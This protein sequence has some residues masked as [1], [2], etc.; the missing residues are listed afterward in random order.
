MAPG[1][2]CVN[3]VDSGTEAAGGCTGGTEQAD[4]S[5]SAAAAGMRRIS[6]ALGLGLRRTTGVVKDFIYCTVESSKC[7]AI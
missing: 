6:R 1:P 3:A 7:S 4:R 5:V 2:A